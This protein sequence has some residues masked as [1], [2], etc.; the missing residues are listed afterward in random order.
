[1]AHLSHAPVGPD[2]GGDGDHDPGTRGALS[3]QGDRDEPPAVL[4]VEDFRIEGEI[5]R[6]A[7]STTEGRP[8]GLQL[9]A[10]EPVPRL[11]EHAEVAV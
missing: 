2:G 6:L 3:P 1:M 9:G 11:V 5:R 7:R 4:V 8:E 10:L